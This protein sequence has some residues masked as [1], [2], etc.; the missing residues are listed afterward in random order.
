MAKLHIQE[1]GGLVHTHG[2]VAGYP[3][4][5]A[6]DSQ[7]VTY[8]VNAVS[9]AFGDNT[10]LIRVVSDGL[11]FIVVGETPVATANS[12]RLPADVVEYFGVKPG[13]KIAAYDGVST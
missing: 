12:M 6:L 4:E 7:V 3:K 10:R 8:T 5:P 1:Y 9:N 2:G 13:D 11:A